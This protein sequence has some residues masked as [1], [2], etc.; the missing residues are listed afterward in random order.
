MLITQISSDYKI[1]SVKNAFN[2]RISRSVVSYKKAILKRSSN[3]TTYA[4]VFFQLNADIRT[5]LY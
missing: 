3:L 5:K 1:L 4:G 2:I